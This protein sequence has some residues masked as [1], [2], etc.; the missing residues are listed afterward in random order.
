MQRLFA[1]DVFRGL[2]ILLMIM[3]NSPGTYGTFSHAYWDGITFADYVF[4]FFVVIVGVAIALGFKADL[5]DAA[6]RQL[7]Q[8]IVKRS[9]IMFA[10][11]L[12]VNLLYLKFSDIRVL[13]VLQ[14]LAIVYLVCS[15]LVLYCQRRTLWLTAA[16]LLVGYWLLILLVPAPGLVAGQLERGANLINW[17]DSAFLPGMLWRGSWDPEGILSTIPAIASGLA[18]VLIGQ[19]IR[20]HQAGGQ[21]SLP[22]LVSQLFVGGFVACLL[23]WLWSLQF[24]LIKQIWSSSFVLVTSGMA[25]MCLATLIYYTDIAGGRRFTRW[26]V[27]FGSNAIV[28]YVLHVAIEK[29]LEVPLGDASV[30]AWYRQLAEAAGFNQFCTVGLW[31]LVF[32]GICYL[33]VWWLYRRQIFIKI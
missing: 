26:P 15:L 17:F 32:L 3:V 5:S 1:L 19:L 20:A 10:L 11:G 9:C 27:V 6:R 25:A 2:T 8:K 30:L 31:T 14:R 7:V 33:P 18:G 21:Q 23:G 29:L 22:L 4:P 16:A 13:G 12:L 28:A 24:P